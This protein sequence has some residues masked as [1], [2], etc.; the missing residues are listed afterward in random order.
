MRWR[1]STY[2]NNQ[3][4]R[5]VVS[6]H[7]HTHNKRSLCW[8]YITNVLFSTR[9]FSWLGIRVLISMTVTRHGGEEVALRTQVSLRHDSPEGGARPSTELWLGRLLISTQT[10][11]HLWLCYNSYQGKSALLRE[12]NLKGAESFSGGWAKKCR[13]YYEI[14]SL[15]W[16]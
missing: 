16:K 10:S 15:S 13:F 6:F 5:R 12:F 4:K 2:W 1:K 7:R 14:V 9:Q 11:R 3:R 8:A